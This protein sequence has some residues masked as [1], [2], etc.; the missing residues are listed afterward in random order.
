MLQIN[1]DMSNFYTEACACT[2]KDLAR[3]QE[4]N[5]KEAKCLD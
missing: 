2:E 5:D 3:R 4:Q 1:S